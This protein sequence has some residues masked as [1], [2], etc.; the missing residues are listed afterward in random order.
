MT[1]DR[2][3]SYRSARC[4][5]APGRRAIVSVVLSPAARRLLLARG[6]LR[7]AAVVAADPLAGGSGFGRHVLLRL[8]RY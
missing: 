3:S 2:P 8:G 6:R 7:V 4:T 5:I 1:L